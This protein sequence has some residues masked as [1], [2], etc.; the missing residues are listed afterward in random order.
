VTCYCASSQ[1]E[2]TPLHCAAA[3]NNVE[4]LQMLVANGADVNVI[5]KVLTFVFVF[6]VVHIILQSVC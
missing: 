3:R 1:D 2:E 4:C 5:D 6:Y